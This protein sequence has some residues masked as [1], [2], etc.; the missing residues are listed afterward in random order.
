MLDCYK[1]NPVKKNGTR[2]KQMQASR[3][4]KRNYP[5]TLNK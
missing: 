3:I 1:M 2:M 4:F 5:I